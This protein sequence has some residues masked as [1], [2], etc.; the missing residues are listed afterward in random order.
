MSIIQKLKDIFKKK[1][2][3]KIEKLLRQNESP[4]GEVSEGVVTHYK[5]GGIVDG[6]RKNKLEPGICRKCGHSF[7]TEDDWFDTIENYVV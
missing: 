2:N 7:P 3:E 5:C 1:Q 4:I 6:D